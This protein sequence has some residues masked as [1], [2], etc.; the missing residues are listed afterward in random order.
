MN[1]FLIVLDVVDQPVLILGQFKE[2][3]A[4][5]DLFHLASAFR[6]IA[7]DEILF[8]PEPFVGSAIPALVTGLVDFP[9]IEKLLQDVPD[10]DLVPLFRGA[11]EI[12][13]A[14]IEAD[15]KL[16]EPAIELVNLFLGRDSQVF[17]RLMHFLSMLVG[18]GEKKYLVPFQFFV[19]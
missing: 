12:V 2:V 8:R 15:P 4:F 13:V 9:F 3:I 7:V 5:V 1:E 6:A 17:C 10:D 18:S 16:L 11:D 14:D 19:A